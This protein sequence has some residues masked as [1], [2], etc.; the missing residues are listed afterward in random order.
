MCKLKGNYTVGTKGLCST[1]SLINF[2]WFLQGNFCSKCSKRKLLYLLW[3]PGRFQVWYWFGRNEYFI[4]SYASADRP[5]Y[6]KFSCK[7]TE[8]YGLWLEKLVFFTKSISFDIKQEIPWKSVYFMRIY[9][10]FK[11]STPNGR[12]LSF[13]NCPKFDISLISL[14]SVISL[15]I[16]NFL[17][18]NCKR[19]ETLF[20]K[21]FKICYFFDFIEIW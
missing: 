17:W 14:K 11:T 18:R 13:E 2:I 3:S 21:L 12:R 1:D 8:R 16:G 10:K 19:Y 20:W 5:K 4:G 15:K 7:S 6:W 9:I